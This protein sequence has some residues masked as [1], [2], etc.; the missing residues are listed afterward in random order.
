MPLIE[1]KTEIK[2]DIKT[3]FDLARDIDLYQKSL[4]NS[5][6]IAVDGKTTGLVEHNDSIVWEATHFGFVRHLNLKVTEFES[7]YLFVDEMVDGYY[8]TYKHE[9]IF[10]ELKNNHD[11]NNN[12][13]VTIMTDRFYFQSNGAVGKLVDWLFLKRYMTKLL[14]SRNKLLKQKAESI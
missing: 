12:G 7:P 11:K 14:V 4:K 3:C 8:K 13:T 1:T 9:H 10:K 5:N 6:E 2:A